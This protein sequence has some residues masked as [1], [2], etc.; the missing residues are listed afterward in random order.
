MLLLELGL[1]WGR[2]PFGILVRPKNLSTLSAS[3][4]AR[5]ERPWY[6]KCRC[7]KGASRVTLLVHF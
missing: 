1:E 3:T 5:V 2:I 6:N 7:L 4:V